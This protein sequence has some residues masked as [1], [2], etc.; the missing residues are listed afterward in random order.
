MQDLRLVNQATV[1]LHPTIPNPYTLLSLLPPSTKIYTCLDLKD[2]FC[3]C[4]DLIFQP[5]FA[6]EKEDPAGGTKQQL[7]WTQLPHG[8]KNSPTNFGE[9][10]ASD[11]DSFQ[12]ERFR[13]RLL[14]YVDDLLLIAKNKEDCWEGIKALLELLMESGYRVLKKKAQICK[15]EIRYSG[16][17]E[18]RHKAVR[19]VQKR[20]HF[21]NRTTKKQTTGPRVLG[22]HWVL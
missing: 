11:L 14:Q 17:V 7:T 21:E 15:E 13:C 4:L 9:A 8:F 6:F 16:F 20:H 19:Q 10:L 2:A 22:S 18:R 5:T 3:I 1:T 12:P